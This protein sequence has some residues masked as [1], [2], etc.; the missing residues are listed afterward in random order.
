MADFDHFQV[1]F[2]DY[3]YSLSKLLL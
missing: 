3:M 1:K 2:V